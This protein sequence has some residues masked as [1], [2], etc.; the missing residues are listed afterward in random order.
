[1][2]WLST[3]EGAGHLG[4][5]ATHFNEA[6]DW[7]ER[8]GTEVDATRSL[9]DALN[10][11]QA[12]W[13]LLE[14]VEEMGEVKTFQTMLQNA[15]DP[16]GRTEFLLSDEVERL[17]GLEPKIMNH[18]VLK[19]HGYRPGVE[20]ATSLATKASEVHGQAQSAL[21]AFRAGETEETRARLLKQ[22][23]ELLYIVR[24]NI[25]HGEKTSRGPDYEKAKR[26]KAVSKLVIPVQ[27]LLINLLLDRPDERLIIY[28]TLAPGQPNHR[29][30]EDLDGDFSGC[31]VRGHVIETDGL[32]FFTWGAATGD[33]KAQLLRSRQLPDMWE[34]L[35]RFEGG[36]YKR[37]LIPAT[38]GSGLLVASIYVSTADDWWS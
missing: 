12:E 10:K 14:N 22:L 4:E 20:I 16:E 7:L 27:L 2:S 11:I 9:S 23:A 34:S 35:D 28:G 17:L 32:P 8:E 1:M 36:G 15:L 5:A 26:D 3:L 31:S 6:L 37:R 21:A 29:I 19:R 13:L 38:T 25:A 18:N 33:V 30:I 24:S